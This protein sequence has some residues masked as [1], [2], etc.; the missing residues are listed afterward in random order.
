MI[1]KSE[2]AKILELVHIEDIIEESLKKSGSTYKCCC[3]FHDE[4]TPSFVVF[5]KTNTYK[6]F[7][8]G[9]YGNAIDYLMNKYG[10]S[11]P[12]AIKKIAEHY[13]TT[14]LEEEDHEKTE[15]EKQDDLKRDL[16]IR[17]YQKVHQF[18]VKNLSE[19]DPEATLARIYANDRWGEEFVNQYGIGYAYNDYQKLHD[20]ALEEKIPE[21]ILI[22]MGLLAKKEETGRIYDA[23]RGRIMIPI[24][25]MGQILIGYT[26]RVVDSIVTPKGN[27]KIPKYINSTTN[28]LYHKDQT[29]FGLDTAFSMGSSKNLF[30]MVEGAPDVLRLQS[31]GIKNTVASLGSD[32]TDKQLKKLFRFSHNVCL[33]PDID[34]PAEGEKYGT[35]IKKVMKTGER[36]LQLGF[37]SV[38]VKEICESDSKKK[39]STE[40]KQKYDAD[41]YFTDK[42]KF[43][44]VSETPY[45]VWYAAKLNAVSPNDKVNN[46]STIAKLLSLVQDAYKV[47]IL[48]EEIEPYI[49]VTQKVWQDA[50]KAARGDS[51]KKEILD[52]ADS[53]Y[54]DA[55]ALDEYGFQEQG[56]TYIS[57]GRDKKIIKWSNFVLRP[58][59]HIKDSS[60]SSRLFSIINED[61]QE[62]VVQMSQEDLASRVRFSIK[63]ESLGNYIFRAKDEQLI[64]LK[65]YLYKVTNTAYMVHQMGWHRRGEFYAFGNGL[66][67]DGKWYKA[68]KLG[69]VKLNAGTPEEVSYFF[70]SVSS[71]NVNN[72]DSYKFER[73]FVHIPIAKFTLKEYVNQMILCYG[74]NAKVCFAF[75]VA[76]LFRDIVVQ[77]T[78][79]FPILNI[80]GVI[81]TGKSELAITLMSFFIIQNKAVSISNST[82][83]SLA[84][85]VAKCSNALV[86][87]EEYKNI[88]GPERIEFLKGLW[89]GMGRTRMGMGNDK[90]RETTDIEAGV[91]LTG[92][93]IPNRDNALLNRT[94]FLRTTKKA[95]QCTPAERRYYEQ[96]CF[97]RSQGCTHLTLYLLKYRAM[98]ATNFGAAYHTAYDDI[99]AA[100]KNQKV[101]ERIFNNW[102]VPVAAIH[103]LR[104]VEDIPVDYNDLVSIAA[105]G[106]LEQNNESKDGSDVAAFWNTIDSLYRKGYL[107]EECDYKIKLVKELK[108]MVRKGEVEVR[109]FDKATEVLFLRHMNILDLYRSHARELGVELLTKST[110][111]YYI[112]Q[113]SAFFGL[114]TSMRF[115]NMQ[116]GK[117]LMKKET[118]KRKDGSEYE[119]EVKSEDGPQ[120]YCFDY[121]LLRSAYD[122]Q[123]HSLNHKYTEDDGSDFITEDPDTSA[124][125][126]T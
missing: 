55:K 18:F 122:L 7:G 110:L 116:N 67:Y 9:A 46:V 102:L 123:L 107:V 25:S 43:D 28:L 71:I 82:I 94:I 65:R 106:I 21:D 84:D 69:V 5:P 50:I 89:D 24:R 14:V 49:Q 58:L 56:N 100:L 74:D 117:V 38:T 36:C 34:V 125:D 41:S 47:S 30:Y 11:Y 78:K 22:E 103:A 51:A 92:Q 126:A 77:Q 40:K 64:A 42:D 37:D 90:S 73:R 115:V 39:K 2:V 20:F 19:V 96:L 114:G 17:T 52:V 101:E 27:K 113:D 98:F 119:V 8:C 91:I 109:Q 32:W 44:K 26:A 15:Q 48:I 10:Y 80:F 61:D 66:V 54:L 120:P 35:G 6:C 75:F 4:K 93:E 118:R 29:V 63:V 33:I 88:I 13:N 1:P 62:Q 16:M 53:Q 121:S 57:I 108:I 23:Y 81:G 87:I 112:K 59:Y 3:P 124:E 76:T 68:N 31:I 104:N 111:L 70:P 99:R 86:H 105:K 85:A 97:M 95:D 79:S 60:Y 45:I 83:A 72:S 12:Q